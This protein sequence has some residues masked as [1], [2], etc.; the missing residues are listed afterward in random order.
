MS[1]RALTWALSTTVPKNADRLVLFV[2]ADH[3]SGED[4]Q[5]WPGIELI[6]RE[7]NLS[8]KT[9]RAALR[10]LIESGHIERVVNGAPLPK[11]RTTN[12]GR[13]NLYTLAVGWD[14]RTPIPPESGCTKLGHPDPEPG[15]TNWAG[16]G[17]PN[18]DTQ[19]D[20]TYICEP[21]EEPSPAALATPAPP[22]APPERTP[23]QRAKAL[24]DAYWTWCRDTYSRDPDIAFVALTKLIVGF[25]EQGVE[26]RRIGWAVRELHQDGRPI[27]RATIGAHIDGRGVRRNARQDA[28]AVVGELRFDEAG[29]LIE[30]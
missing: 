11:G 7:A 20:H 9:T 4:H 5:T 2:L 3:A 29:N 10:S 12:T 6:A 17:V 22:E 24:A 13:R 21:K 30:Q 26:E 8:E 15:V 16:P 19:P 14:D 23:A 27:T 1:N 28:V 25:I 18:W